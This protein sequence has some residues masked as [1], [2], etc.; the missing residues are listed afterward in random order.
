MKSTTAL[1]LTLDPMLGVVGLQRRISVVERV[2]GVDVEVAGQAHDVPGE[3]LGAAANPM[4]QNE[5][6]T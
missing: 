1:R 5:G 4:Y 2:D 3:H 6:I